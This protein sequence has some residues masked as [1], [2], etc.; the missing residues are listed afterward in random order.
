MLYDKIERP[1]RNLTAQELYYGSKNA[2][3]TQIGGIIGKSSSV[4]KQ[5]RQATGA[6]IRMEEAQVK[7]PDRVVVVVAPSAIR[8]KIWL[9]TTGLENVNGG[10]EE[11]IEVG[12][13]RA[14]F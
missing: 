10:G 4:N 6:K 3:G 12:W 11:E 7:S 13:F 9:R 5:L 2:C 1:V 14:G 8:S